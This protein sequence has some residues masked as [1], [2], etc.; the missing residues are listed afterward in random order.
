MR[1]R[2]SS[3]WVGEPAQSAEFDEL[4][5]DHL[6]DPDGCQ[7]VISSLMDEYVQ[8]VAREHA[9]C[10]GCPVVR[11]GPLVISSMLDWKARRDG[12]LSHWQRRDIR[13]FLDD[14]FRHEVSTDRQRMLDATSGATDLA[15]FMS[16][17]GSLIGDDV[18]VLV[19][20]A[21]DVFKELTVGVSRHRE[22]VIVSPRA[23]E[24]VAMGASFAQVSTS[25]PQRRAKRKAA[26]AARKRNRR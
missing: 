5:V 8:Y 3:P 4:V 13:T 14:H 21:D 20:A 15:Y 16:D 19:A 1:D 6:G 9:L 24:L 10:L 26:R 12:R 2:T 7:H 22:P 25:A 17:R 11:S 23:A 18:H